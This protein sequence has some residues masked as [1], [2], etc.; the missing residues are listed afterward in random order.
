M[1]RRGPWSSAELHRS[2]PRRRFSCFAAS[3]VG[4]GVNSWTAD[5]ARKVALSTDLLV[6]PSDPSQVYASD[7]RLFRSSDSGATWESTQ[8]PF[9]PAFEQLLVRRRRSTRVVSTLSRVPVWIAVRAS[10][11]SLDGGCDLDD[12]TRQILPDTQRYPIAVRSAGSE[13]ASI[14]RARFSVYRS[15]DRGD[16]LASG[17]EPPAAVD[18]SRFRG[19]PS[20][21]CRASS[22]S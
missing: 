2:A 7:L 16:S 15:R 8:A 21:D 18:E 5:R 1:I 14:M 3:G 4:A 17:L 6:A 22:W 20:F 12:R 10:E 11:R 13:P 9:E 19:D